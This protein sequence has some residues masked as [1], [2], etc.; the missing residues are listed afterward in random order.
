MSGDGSVIGNFKATFQAA[1][2]AV[3]GDSTS[4]AANNEVPSPDKAATQQTKGWEGIKQNVSD[5][6]SGK[7]ENMDVGRFVAGGALAAVGGA[8][9]PLTTL[10]TA[11]FG[12]AG[13]IADKVAPKIPLGGDKSV[14]WT[15][16]GVTFGSFATAFVAGLGLHMMATSGEKREVRAYQ[17]GKQ[18]QVR[19]QEMKPQGKT[20]PLASY[21]ERV[22]DFR[23]ELG[24]LVS[25]QKAI[26][27][28]HLQGKKEVD[29][30]FEEVNQKI[31]TFVGSNKEILG[32]DLVK[33]FQKEFDLEAKICKSELLKKEHEE[34]KQ[35]L[36]AIELRKQEEQEK[37]TIE[38][39]PKPV[40]L[41]EAKSKL[42][43]LKEKNTQA[44]KDFKTGEKEAP[45]VLE[46][47]TA[48]RA[49]EKDIRDKGDAD[50][51]GAEARWAEKLEKGGK[52][53]A[54][55]AAKTEE[56]PVQKP[57]TQPKFARRQ[58]ESK[59]KEFRSEYESKMNEANELYKSKQNPA[60]LEMLKLEILE[61]DRGIRNCQAELAK[62]PLTKQQLES[63]IES[64]KVEIKENQEER[65]QQLSEQSNLLEQLFDARNN[66]VKKAELELD[67]ERAKTKAESL[68]KLIE[69]RT[70]ELEILESELADV[71]KNESAPPEISKEQLK[72]QLESSQEKLKRLEEQRDENMLN[73]L[74]Y[75]QLDVK[76]QNKIKSFDELIEFQ[77]AKIQNLEAEL[78]KLG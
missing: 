58:L 7:F 75:D 71:Q 24:R 76:Q 30:K 8:L 51:A 78:K 42:E 39:E 63:E 10:S 64:C 69:A 14:S 56:T 17:E 13:F 74:A 59:M 26:N 12:G 27:A 19:A 20:D 5:F 55:Q 47:T 45:K 70:K 35:E 50:V 36:S 15:A 29:K 38:G 46:K 32:E 9:L 60:R 61:L 57:V 43:D 2:K 37:I 52:Q 54:K 11:I 18:E 53:A 40:P 68:G 66:P 65:A 41:T 21:K 67:I 1:F 77:K 22:L 44:L 31:E 6:V 72:S 33:N 48:E 73:N 23:A 25:E 28:T 4:I 3:G 34:S 62:V 49:K 16:V